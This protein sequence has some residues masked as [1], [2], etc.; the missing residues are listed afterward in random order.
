MVSFFRI[1]IIDIENTFF[2]VIS[3]Q[4]DVMLQGERSAEGEISLAAI[5]MR[6]KKYDRSSLDHGF[7][8]IDL[9]LLF[10]PS[11]IHLRSRQS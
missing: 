3:S 6:D 4:T 1:G 5:C 11:A 7:E 2:I 8:D 10:H 9:F